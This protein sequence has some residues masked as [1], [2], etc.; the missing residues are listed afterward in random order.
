M[1]INVMDFLQ[2]FLLLVHG[3]RI[4]LINNVELRCTV[5]QDTLASGWLRFY[6]DGW[7]LLLGADG[8]FQ[9]FV[10]LDEAFAIEGWSVGL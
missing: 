9:F 2:Q 10:D 5:L 1:A 6:H 8:L 4:K 7:K 3:L